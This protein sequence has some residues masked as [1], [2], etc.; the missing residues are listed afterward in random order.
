[1]TFRAI[2]SVLMLVVGISGCTT[3][4]V[5]VQ[6]THPAEI[7]MSPYKRIAIGEI[8]GNMGQYYSDRIK[9]RLVESGR[10]EVVDRSQLGSILRERS[11]SQS[12][13]ANPNKQMK[14]GKLIGAAA[15]IQ[16][17][18]SGQ[19]SEEVTYRQS[20]CYASGGVKYTCNLY[21]RRGQVRT[22][23]SI[24]VIDVQTGKIIKSKPLNAT[25]NQK[26]GPVEGTPPGIDKDGLSG[27][28]LG[29]NVMTLIKAI[30][31][32][33]E[34]VMAA[35]VKDDAMPN[36]EKGIAYAKAGDMDEAIRIFASTAKA[37]ETS[38][39][40]TVKP[41]PDGVAPEATGST[42][43][44]RS[45]GKMI[46]TV[47]AKAFESNTSAQPESIANAYWNLGLAYEYSREFD[48]AV[49]AF[50]KANSFNPKPEYTSE[51]ANVQRLKRQHTKLK[52][53]EEA[54]AGQR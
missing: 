4:K 32:W 1:M 48:K 24:D 23:G 13:S 42:D 43:I 49:E 14:S 44:F 50:K 38:N 8:K 12:D 7:D 36:L 47:S 35:F 3:V 33:R 31:P 28:C 39:N 22:D 16:G 9:N 29:E 41:A 5:P 45:I 2:I 10:F 17:H 6:V 19:Y 52:T 25:C 53:Q 21:T 15:L 46:S 27:E 11:L 40:T 51:I 34:T 18:T 20:T 54:F 26:T 30:S 37:A